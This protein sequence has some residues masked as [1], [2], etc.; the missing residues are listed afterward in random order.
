MKY[1][2]TRILIMT[3]TITGG[4]GGAEIALINENYP[5]IFLNKAFTIHLYEK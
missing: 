2:V 4:G 3:V 1:S 5:I